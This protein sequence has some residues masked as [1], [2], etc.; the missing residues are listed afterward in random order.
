MIRRAMSRTTGYATGAR[1]EKD[2]EGDGDVHGQ[3]KGDNTSS[4]E[5][6]KDYYE[7]I[8]KRYQVLTVQ[9]SLELGGRKPPIRIPTP[10][11]PI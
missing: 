6:E 5:E 10:P 8:L 4:S 7:L 2:G 3:L 11:T 1:H 9:I